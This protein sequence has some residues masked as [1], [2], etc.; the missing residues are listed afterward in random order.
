MFLIL[1]IGAVD[2]TTVITAETDVNLAAIVVSRIPYVAVASAI[3]YACY[4]LARL[5]ITEVMNIN[6]QRLS[7]TKISIIAKD[8]SEAAE[9]RLGFS[10]EQ[11]YANRLKVKMALLGDHIKHLIST[12]PELLFPENLFALPAPGERQPT[13]ARRRSTRT[14]A[15][16]TTDS[17][18][19]GA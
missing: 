19:A 13:Q 14:K 8:I 12:E 6:R 16:A 5:F 17:G 10:E 9:S 18:Q 7:L 1:I 2:L 4:R 15:P 11:I 3:I